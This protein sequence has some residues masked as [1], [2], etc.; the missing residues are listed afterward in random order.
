MIGYDKATGA[1]CFFELKEGYMPLE[2]GVPAGKVP[3]I[4]APD[5]EDAWKRPESVA[6]QGC[7]TC[8]TPDP[9]IHTPYVDAARWPADPAQPVV[10]QI[11]TTTSPYFV[12]GDA[13]ASWTFD[14]VEF[15]DNQCT[16]CHRMPDFRRFTFGSHVDFNAHMPPLAPG[17]M[18]ADFDAVMACLS[19][20]PDTAPGCRWAAL[21]GA[22]PTTDGAIK[23]I[24]AI[25]S[26][27]TTFGTLGVAD[28]FSVSSGTLTGTGAD[29]QFSKVG[30][31]AGTAPSAGL[32]Q[33]DVIGHQEIADVP[34]GIDYIARFLVPVEAFSPGNVVS[35]SAVG[36]S[37][38]LLI[39]DGADRSNTFALGTTG[40][41]QLNLG[42]VGAV[43]GDAVAG[44]FSIL[45]QSASKK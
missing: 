21:N 41:G 44:D 16:S 28:P 34:Q 33:I 24:Q 38:E 25:G 7:N 1:T 30:A 18:K 20:G 8:H 29:F 42:N 32:V 35:S 37:S 10:P 5:Y 36:W 2:E 13:F 3:G 26:F 22:T 43:S 11:A 19:Q 39:A 40:V 27:Q 31:I 17:S 4:D 12:L 23:T 6:V 45:W 15:D 9:F 14:Y